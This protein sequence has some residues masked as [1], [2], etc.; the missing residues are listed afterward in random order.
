MYMKIVD[1][2]TAQVTGRSELGGVD[3]HAANGLMSLGETLRN[4]EET[5]TCLHETCAP[6]RPGRDALQLNAID[7][8]RRSPRR[9]Q[10]NRRLPVGDLQLSNGH[11]S[12]LG[13]KRSLKGSHTGFRVPVLEIP[14][15]NA[16][17][18]GVRPPVDRIASEA[19]ALEN[20]DHAF[21]RLAEGTGLRQVLVPEATKAVSGI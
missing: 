17:C 8:P 1:A 10:G 12:T 7:L 2:E 16:R 15:P 9:Q 21:D 13:E 18:R 19:V 14:H 4:P 11:A 20:L 5:V 3:L 6:T